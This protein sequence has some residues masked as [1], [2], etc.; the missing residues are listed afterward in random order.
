ML[1]TISK[2]LKGHILQSY[3]QKNPFPCRTGVISPLVFQ[4]KSLPVNINARLI[5]RA[6]IFC[7]ILLFSCFSFFTIKFFIGLILIF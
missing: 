2:E 6:L 4:F 3:S 1:L 5:L 7:I